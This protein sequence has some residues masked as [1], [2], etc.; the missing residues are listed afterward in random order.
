[1]DGSRRR[2]GFAVTRWYIGAS[3][4]WT[5]SEMDSPILTGGDGRSGVAREDRAQRLAQ[6]EA[7]TVEGLPALGRVRLDDA[8]IDGWNGGA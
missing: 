8:H 7:A 2:T 1:M 4:A 6:L 3:G 5:P